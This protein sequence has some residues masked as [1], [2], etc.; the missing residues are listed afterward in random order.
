MIPAL[1]LFAAAALD[2]PAPPVRLQCSFTGEDPTS[3]EQT[4]P[5]PIGFA[6]DARGNRVASVVIDDPT[7]IFTSG[8]VVGFISAGPSGGHYAEAPRAEDPR[9][10]GRIE[11]GR[12]GLTGTRREVTLTADPHGAGS[13]TGRLRYEVGGPAS[14]S[15]VKDGA[16]SCRPTP[17]A[18]GNPQ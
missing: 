11:A 6:I 10:R 3:P 18:E 9:W 12:I 13:W 5:R 2:P 16:L 8:N 7:G 1:L 15:L 17:A 4:G 14:F